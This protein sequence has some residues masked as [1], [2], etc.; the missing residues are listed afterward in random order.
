[1]QHLH[2]KLAFSLKKLPGQRSWHLQPSGIFVKAEDVFCAW[3]DSNTRAILLSSKNLD[4]A[5]RK[6]AALCLEKQSRTWMS[7][8]TCSEVHGWL[9]WLLRASTY[10]QPCFNL[11]F[12]VTLCRSSTEN[13]CTDRLKHPSP[14]PALVQACRVLFKKSWV[15]MEEKNNHF[16]QKDCSYSSI[17]CLQTWNSGVPFCSVGQ[18]CW[19]NWQML[20]FCAIPGSCSSDAPLSLQLGFMFK[21]FNF[22]KGAPR[23]SPP[24]SEIAGCISVPLVG[25]DSPRLALESWQLDAGHIDWWWGRDFLTTACCYWLSGCSYCWLWGNQAFLGSGYSLSSLYRKCIVIVWK[26]FCIALRLQAWQ[27]FN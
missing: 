13:L 5:F 26:H 20:R 21:R 8:W 10:P 1:M 23:P 17:N 18:Q 4:A 24:P 9:F 16:T 19:M 14:A 12:Q 6:E 25:A 22:Q 11:C 3:S 27:L 7:H 2:N 15:L